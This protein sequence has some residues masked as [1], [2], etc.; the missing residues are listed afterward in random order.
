MFVQGVTGFRHVVKEVDL[1]PRSTLARDQSSQSVEH[2]LPDSRRV[3][4]Q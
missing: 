1:L 3:R 2:V 4:L